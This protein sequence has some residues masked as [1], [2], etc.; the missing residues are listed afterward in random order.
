MI[1]IEKPRIET[2]ELSPDGSYGKFIVE[3]L[4]RGGKLRIYQYSIF[5]LLRR[6]SGLLCGKVC[7][8]TQYILPSM[9]YTS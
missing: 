9:C 5:H 3:P 2:A 8:L 4:E 7:R 6:A 1:E